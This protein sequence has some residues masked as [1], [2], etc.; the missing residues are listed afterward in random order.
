ML[1]LI[2]CFPKSGSTFVSAVISKL[3][4]YQRANFNEWVGT[5][6]NITVP[7][8]PLSSRR[9]QELSNYVVEQYRGADVVAQ[10]HVKASVFTLQLIRRHRI[11]TIVLVRNIFDCVISFADHLMRESPE[12]PWIYLDE[13]IRQ[14]SDQFR[15]DAIV[16]LVCPWYIDFYVSWVKNR[17]QDIYRYEDVVLA[18]PAALHAMLTKA[19]I[20]V[21]AGTGTRSVTLRDV[22]AALP[23][24]AP[25]SIRLN[26]GIA[27]RGEQLLSAANKAHLRRLAAHHPDVDFSPTGL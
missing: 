5:L 25:D 14:K 15:Y 12:V 8:I 20:T 11:A 17:P 22:E 16:D 19:G 4:G 21:P 2:A 10:H 18:G 7:E 9:E 26:V 1:V 24:S 13:S 23:A 3:P 27:G 6:P